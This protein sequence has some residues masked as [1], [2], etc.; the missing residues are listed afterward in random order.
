MLRPVKIAN[1]PVKMT[2]TPTGV[3]TR[4]PLLGEHTREVLAE[5][6]YDATTIDALVANRAVRVPDAVVEETQ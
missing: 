1:T 2:A 6:G 3:R 4:G 5:A